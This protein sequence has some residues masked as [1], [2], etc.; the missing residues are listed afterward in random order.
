MAAKLEALPFKN[1]SHARHRHQAK[2]RVL[3]NESWAEAQVGQ[4]PNREPCV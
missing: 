2:G 3:N 1:I 4:R